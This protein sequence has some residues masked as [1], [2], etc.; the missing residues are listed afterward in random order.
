MAV[1]IGINGFGRIGRLVL[2]GIMESRR[3]DVEVV[4]INDLGSV[5]MNAHLLKYDSVHG[6]LAADI[7]VDE[8]TIDVGSG[9]IKVTAESNPAKLPWK[10]LGVDVAFECTG[11]FKDRMNPIKEWG[12]ECG[13]GVEKFMHFLNKQLEGRG[14]KLSVNDF[15]FRATYWGGSPSAMATAIGLFLDDLI[16]PLAVDDAQG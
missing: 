11:Y 7:D 10:N 12:E 15:N 2:R 4:G 13:Q 16:D 14:V 8:D 5:E 3:N 1:R 6:T 9:P